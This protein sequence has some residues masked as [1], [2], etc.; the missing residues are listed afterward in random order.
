MASG[1]GDTSKAKETIVNVGKTFSHIA[2]FKEGNFAV[3]IM[4]ITV[5]LMSVSELSTIMANV[6][7]LLQLFDKY[8]GLTLADMDAKIESET[9]SGWEAKDKTEKKRIIKEIKSFLKIRT[10]TRKIHNNKYRKKTRK[11]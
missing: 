9:S 6:L 1:A 10:H 2:K 8:Q 4:G 3:W 5:T 7:Q 11:K